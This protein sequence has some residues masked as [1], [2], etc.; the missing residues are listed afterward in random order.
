MT[1]I[2][3]FLTAICS[4]LSW[5][6]IGIM[7]LLAFPMIYD[8]IMRTA[9]HPTIW[10]FEL[11][12]YAL[13]TA[14][15]LANAYAL[16]NGSHFRVTFLSKMWPRYKKLFDRFAYATTFLFGLV[17]LVAGL[18]Y[19]YA[20]YEVDQHSATLLN[21]PL[22][23]PRAVVPLGAFGLMAQALISLMTDTYP[24]SHEAPVVSQAE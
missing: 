10:A 17:L 13:I 6:S 23:Y 12:T 3:R 9:H 19:V 16:R 21:I 22:Y 15:F 4:V 2:V 7:S 1:A 5:L 24:E 20:A 18:D 8:V 14:T 11:T